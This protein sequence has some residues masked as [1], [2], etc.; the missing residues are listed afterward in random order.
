M[1]HAALHFS[2]G[3]MTGMGVLAPRVLRALRA[4]AP[5]AVA[6]RQWVVAAWLLGVYALVPSFLPHIGVPTGLCN[7]WWMNVFL[8]HPLLNVL[9]PRG[10]LLGELALLAC[11]AFQYACVL[12]VLIRVKRRQV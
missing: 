8:F 3:M 7:G 9:I 1:A 4:R 12:A 5:A 10:T 6:M 2:V 11:L